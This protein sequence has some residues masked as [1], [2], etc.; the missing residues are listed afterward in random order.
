MLEHKA[1]FAP[2]VDF[3]EASEGEASPRLRVQV[4]YPMDFRPRLLAAQCRKLTLFALSWS[5]SGKA[6]LGRTFAFVSGK[7]ACEAAKFQIRLDFY[8]QA[9]IGWS[10]AKTKTPSLD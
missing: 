4:G 9:S 8:R 5:S 3:A 7:V 2:F 6:V 1:S 10:G